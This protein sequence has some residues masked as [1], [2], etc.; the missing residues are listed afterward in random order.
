MG[1]SFLT[2]SKHR[3]S[4]RVV[5]LSSSLV[6]SPSQQSLSDALT[7]KFSNNRASSLFSHEFFALVN[8]LPKIVNPSD[9][10]VF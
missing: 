7:G 1:K 6:S 4:H 8:T 9:L 5:G 3:F 2:S 10:S